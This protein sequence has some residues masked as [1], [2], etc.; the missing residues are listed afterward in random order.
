MQIINSKSGLE[1]TC[2]LFWW[3]VDLVAVLTVGVDVSIFAA[4]WILITINYRMDVLTL[5]HEIDRAL[6]SDKLT[7]ESTTDN[8]RYSYMRV[9]K[10]AVGVNR[11]SSLILFSLVLCTTPFFCTILF[12]VEYGSNL[13]MSVT[14][15][16]AIM[17]IV[18]FAWS[19]MAITA[20][21][22]S[23][24]ERLYHLLCSLSARKSRMPVV[25]RREQMRLLQILEQ[26]GSEEQ[27][28]ALRTIDGQKYTSETLLY[29]LIEMGL[30]FTLLLT[31]DRA[32]KLR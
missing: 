13:Y 20:E 7:T 21:I 9:V 5:T 11:I 4:M 1:T 22:T 17:P 25:S 31:F 24:S 23:R 3:I 2:W 6:E 14:L 29:Y 16:V 30:Q 32:M 10:Q 26:V 15:F 12:A 18:L 27:L 28:L 8:I 19:L